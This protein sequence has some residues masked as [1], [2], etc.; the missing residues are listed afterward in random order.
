MQ[1]TAAQLARTEADYSRI[2]GEPVALQQIA[3]A[4][5][6]FGSEIATLRLFRKMP[7]CR[8]GYSENRKQFYFCVELKG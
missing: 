6:A 8:Q 4:I 3:G 1:A 5:Y 7:N 2:A